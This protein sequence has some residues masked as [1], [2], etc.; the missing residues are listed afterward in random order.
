MVIASGR[1]FAVHYYKCPESRAV[2]TLWSLAVLLRRYP[3]AVP[4]VDV[5]FDCTDHPRIVKP[6]GQTKVLGEGRELP[7]LLRYS[8]SDNHSDVA[9][10]DWS[11][12][13]WWVPIVNIISSTSI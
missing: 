8:G 4:D 5:L 12:W 1:L 2:I 7:L 10:P 6:S 13:G 11:F 3:G 9:F